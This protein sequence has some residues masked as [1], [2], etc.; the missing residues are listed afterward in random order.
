MGETNTGG[1]QPKLRKTLTLF[2]GITIIIG[3]TIGSG[4]FA[5]PSKTALYFESFGPILTLWIVAAVF[6][7]AGGLIYARSLM[8]G[9]RREDY[10]GAPEPASGEPT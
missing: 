1:A 10:V 8:H 3:I 5:S 7:Y 6:I 2:D 4:I 9:E